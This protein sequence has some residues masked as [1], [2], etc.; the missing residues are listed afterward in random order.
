MAQHF[1]K[2][3]KA[4]YRWRGRRC[5]SLLEWGCT[6]LGLGMGKIQKSMCSAHSATSEGAPSLSLPPSTNYLSFFI[7]C[8]TPSLSL[9][10][11]FGFG[12]VAARQS[13][14]VKCVWVCGRERRDPKC[15]DVFSFGLSGVDAGGSWVKIVRPVLT[16]SSVVWRRA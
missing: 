15:L 10:L 7:L 8:L 6:V 16:A 9:C 1:V 3:S 12:S 14:D 4:S 13:A 2:P 5:S 11:S